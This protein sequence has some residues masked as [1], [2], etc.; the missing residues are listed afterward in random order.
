[1]QPGRDLPGRPPDDLARARTQGAVARHRVVGPGV[2]AYCLLVG[3]LLDSVDDIAGTSPQMHQ[4]IEQLGGA[5]ALAQ[6]FQVAIM[7]FVGIAAA[8]FAVTLVSRLHGEETSG[9]VELV[10][11]TGVS[12]TRYLSS[13]VAMLVVGVV[14]V[15][16]WAGLMMGLGHGLVSGGWGTAF[17]DAV[18]AGLVQVPAALV[19][20]GL[21]LVLYGWWPRLVALGW[22]IVTLVLVVGQLGELFGLPQWAR[23]L[24]PFT[25][26]PRSRWSPHRPPRSSR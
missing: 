13:H 22:G 5:G 4:I 1:M 20:A 12:R 24:S 6:V 8:A 25:H 9:R 17:G 18:G 11:S 2:G 15:P 7:G 19:V 3:F 26:V 14:A 10:L 21:V 16:L 23:D